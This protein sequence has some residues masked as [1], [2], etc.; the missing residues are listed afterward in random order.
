MSVRPQRNLITFP[1]LPVRKAIKVRETSETRH[2]RTHLNDVD[3]VLVAGVGPGV[4]E[5]GVVVLVPGLEEQV[6]RQVP[7]A[8]HRAAVVDEARLLRIRAP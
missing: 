1:T 6:V 2:R 7:G 8:H 3:T 5:A 4:H